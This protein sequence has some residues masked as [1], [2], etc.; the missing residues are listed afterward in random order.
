MGR[1]QAASYQNDSLKSRNKKACL[2][3]FPISGAP[4]GKAALQ[5]SPPWAHIHEILKA[6]LPTGDSNP[7][8]KQEMSPEAR[9]TGKVH[10]SRET[11][12]ACVSHNNGGGWRDQRGHEE[13]GCG[14]N[15]VNC[16]DT[17]AALETGQVCVHTELP[18]ISQG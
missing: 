12:L 2:S 6:V 5:N 3:E 15:G 18:C 16:W 11:G 9:G 13:G 17:V 1:K 14:M 8:Q 7:Q 4:P 10:L